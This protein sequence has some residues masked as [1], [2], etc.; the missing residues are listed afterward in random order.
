MPVIID[1]TSG[2]TFND[3]SVQAASAFFKRNNILGQVTQAAGVPTGAVIERGS[4]AN[5]EFVR[6]AD[7]TQICTDRRDVTGISVA[8]GA[9]SGSINPGG[10][11]AAFVGNASESFTGYATDGNGAR[12][13]IPLITDR[14]AI[15]VVWSFNFLNPTTN[16]QTMTRVVDV[17]R[18]AIGR[19]F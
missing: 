4:N 3:N 10:Y 6:F 8:P 14:P 9:N 1:G 19:W 12:F 17:A 11:P 7:G 16:T 5:G 18:I 13:G 2:V 15:G